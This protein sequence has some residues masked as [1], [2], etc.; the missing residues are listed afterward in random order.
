[1]YSV[2]LNHSRIS[3][4]VAVTFKSVFHCASNKRASLLNRVGYRHLNARI[5]DRTH[6]TND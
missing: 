1:M 2:S 4:L 5:A 6:E 3:D